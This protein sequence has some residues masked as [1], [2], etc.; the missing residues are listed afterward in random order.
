MMERSELRKMRC[1]SCWWLEGGRCFVA[2]ECIGSE[3][4][5]AFPPRCM[6]YESKRAVYERV[7][8]PE[9]LVIASERSQAANAPPPPDK[10]GK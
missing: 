3:I 7:I 5:E 1:W 4:T 10:P 6:L 2:R 9:M 8:Q